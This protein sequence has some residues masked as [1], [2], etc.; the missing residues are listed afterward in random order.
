MLLRVTLST[1]YLALS[2][3]YSPLYF[4]DLVGIG[5]RISGHFGQSSFPEDIRSTL[6]P[7]TL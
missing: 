5:S 7:Q 3:M 2:A 4:Q 1:D 6:D